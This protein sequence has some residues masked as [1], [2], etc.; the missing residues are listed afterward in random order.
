M[1]EPILKISLETLNYHEFG[2]RNSYSF[3]NSINKVELQNPKKKKNIW[4]FHNVKQN[5]DDLTSSFSTTNNAVIKN[6]QKF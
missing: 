2:K 6:F 5:F 4:K 1:D 3:E